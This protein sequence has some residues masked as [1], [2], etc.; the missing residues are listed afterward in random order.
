MENNAT[1]FPNQVGVESVENN[2]EPF[3]QS[4]NIANVFPQLKPLAK[5]TGSAS[6]QG[7]P[8]LR[9]ASMSTHRNNTCAHSAAEYLL[10][11]SCYYQTVS[12]II[13]SG[14]LTHITRTGLETY[15]NST[16]LNGEAV[17]ATFFHP[18][19]EVTCRRGSIWYDLEKHRNV[20][21]DLFPGND[22]A[23]TQ[24]VSVSDIENSKLL[25]D[26]TT[27]IIARL[28]PSSSNRTSTLL[29]YARWIGDLEWNTFFCTIDAAW[30]EADTR[31]TREAGMTIIN[32]EGMVNNSDAT[33]YLTKRRIIVK[34]DIVSN[35]TQN[36]ILSTKPGDYGFTDETLSFSLAHGLSNMVPGARTI[37][38]PFDLGKSLQSKIRTFLSE[39]G[40][41]ISTPTVFWGSGSLQNMTIAKP[42]LE[43][44]LYG[45]RLDS[46]TVILSLTV[47][48][49]YSMI[50]TIHLVYTFITGE[51]STSWDTVS[52]LFMLAL[53]T[54]IPS[55]IQ[56]TSA[57]VATLSTL[58]E[59]VTIKANESGSLEVVFENDPKI[60]PSNFKKI[61]PNV[62]YS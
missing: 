56:N 32:A 40:L 52:E 8:G 62:E 38:S 3:E 2:L 50:A 29:V 44:E 26:N 27:S 14:P 35:F 1:L 57:G 34:P 22:P 18:L 21:L 20:A 24:V 17:L 36:L 61:E 48:V 4:I 19:V 13:P 59:L 42:Q 15:Y 5:T 30:I 60:Q 9:V 55:H 11:T 10:S 33:Q 49:V 47:L 58:K 43:A 12:T 53:N 16:R 37:Y 46:I 6:I 39:R 25:E 51:T 45:Y 28:S 31:F 23:L 7:Y 41:D 54:R